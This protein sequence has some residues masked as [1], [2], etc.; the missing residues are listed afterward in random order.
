MNHGNSNEPRRDDEDHRPHHAVGHVVGQP[1]GAVE[2]TVDAV[3]VKVQVRQRAALAGHVDQ[4]AGTAQ[5]T[6]AVLVQQ[7]Q[8]VGQRRGLGDMATGDQESLVAALHFAPQP[9]FAQRGPDLTVGG[10]ARRHLTG[11]GA[12]VDLDQPALQLPF[13]VG[14]QLG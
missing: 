9:Q 6:K 10:A 13:G 3:Q 11:L 8:H 2:H 5:Q 14:R 4:V 1:E 7:V 12:A